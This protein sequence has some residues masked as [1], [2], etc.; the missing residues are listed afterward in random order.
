[1]VGWM[2]GMDGTVGC[3]GKGQGVAWLS[4]RARLLHGPAVGTGGAGRGA[5]RRRLAG[6][7][8]V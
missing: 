5:W 1:M 4:V 2:E 3:D 8:R 6:V 7:I